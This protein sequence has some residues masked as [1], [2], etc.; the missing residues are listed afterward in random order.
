MK[1]FI[2]IAALLVLAAC[3]G[4]PRYGPDSPYYRY[5]AG[6]RLV[7]NEALE[8]PPDSATTRLQFGRVVPRNGVQEHEPHCI[9]EVNTVA[10][11]ARRVEPDSFE[12]VDVRRSIW[13]SE[14]WPASAARPVKVGLAFG[15]ASP[16]FVFYITEFRLRSAR[17]PDVRTLTCQSNQMAPGIAIMRHLTLAEI[18]QAL[19]AIFTLDLSGA[20]SRL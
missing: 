14:A 16:T 12:V 8:I 1:P 2:A 20:A 3:A 5:P 9:F 15:D 10:A 7:L 18:R 19:G 11:A 17:Q 13:V 6:L 4:S